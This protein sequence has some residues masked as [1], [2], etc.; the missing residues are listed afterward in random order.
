MKNL[1]ERLRFWKWHDCRSIARHRRRRMKAKMSWVMEIVAGAE[2]GDRDTTTTHSVEPS[3]VRIHASSWPMDQSD[4]VSAL[5][6]DLPIFSIPLPITSRWISGPWAALNDKTS[7]LPR[8][9]ELRLFWPAPESYTSRNTIFCVCVFFFC[10][11]RRVQW[12]GSCWKKEG[13]KTSQ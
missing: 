6:S 5:G 8:L 1:W 4:T 13:G 7:S 9:S 10:N 2:H 3:C 11:E 12:V